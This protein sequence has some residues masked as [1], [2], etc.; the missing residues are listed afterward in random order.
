MR[1]DVRELDSL[2]VI[3]MDFDGVVIE[4]NGVKTDAFE[5]VFA[6]FPDHAQTMMA[7]HHAHVS[8]SRFAKFDHLL[9]LLGKSD[10][11]DLRDDIAADFSSRVVGG[12]LRVP[13][14]PGAETFLKMATNGLPVYLASVTPAEELNLI[15]DRRG[16]Y[17]WFRGVYG[18]PPWTKPGAVRDVLTR[19][20]AVPQDALLIGDSAGDQ[21]AARET[22]VRFLARNSGLAFDEP[23]P[24]SFAD[25]NEITAYLKDILL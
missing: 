4:S 13:L 6:R 17:R 5:H 8:L 11:V 9:G 20:G 19:E 1:N 7:F 21:R 18:C 3:I 16:L 12:I 15:L 23:A 22:G 2:R 24:L 14:V 10:D 25:L